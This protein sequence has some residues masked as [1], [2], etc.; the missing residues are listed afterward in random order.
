VDGL[1]KVA[2]FIPVKTTHKGSQLAEYIW[3]RLCLYT[4]YRRRLFWIEDH[5]LPPNFGKSFLE[6]MDTK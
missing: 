6:N 2:H 5:S 3:L 4:V 1:T